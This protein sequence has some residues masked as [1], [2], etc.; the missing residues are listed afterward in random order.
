[1]CCATNIMS[2]DFA[3]P[4]KLGRIEMDN[5][6]GIIFDHFAIWKSKKNYIIFHFHH[7]SNLCFSVIIHQYFNIV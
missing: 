1:M 7:L 3:L 6:E 5:Q 2:L 4:L